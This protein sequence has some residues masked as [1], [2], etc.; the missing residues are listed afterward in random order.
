MKKKEINAGQRILSY[1]LHE[2]KMKSYGVVAHKKKIQIAL[3]LLWFCL[4]GGIIYAIHSL[5]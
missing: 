1:D 4:L 5:R 3:L 2:T